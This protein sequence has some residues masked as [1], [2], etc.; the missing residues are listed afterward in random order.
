MSD[1]LGRPRFQ[2]SEIA[3]YSLAAGGKDERASFAIVDRAYCCLEVWVDYAR[4]SG[5]PEWRRRQRAHAKC[6]ELNAR[7]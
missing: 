5:G 3:G 2:V 7:S 4:S 6:A 1:Y